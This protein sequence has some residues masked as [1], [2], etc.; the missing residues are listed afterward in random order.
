MDK[1][2]DE[3]ILI[4]QAIIEAYRQDSNNNIK[5]LT[6][7]FTGMITSM[8]DKIKIYESSSE[9]KDSPKAQD[10]TSVFP[11]NKRASPLEGGH[12]T[13]VGGIWTLKYEISSPKF[14]EIIIKTELKG[15]T[16]LYLK[17][18]YNHIKMSFNAVT[19]L[20]KYLI[21]TYQSI[22]L[23]SEFEEYF[24]SDCDLPSYS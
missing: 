13:K 10:P 23:R 8:M 17:N 14:Y 6:E 15:D 19:R 11:D 16:C 7:Y 5:N 21:P 20:Q 3:H 22:K 2:S 9:Q 1:K 12:S 24:I 18:F 4:M